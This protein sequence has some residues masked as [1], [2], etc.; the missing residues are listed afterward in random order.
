[1]SHRIEVEYCPRCHWLLRAAWYAQELLSTFEN[2]LE[3]V[4]LK[5]AGSGVFRITLNG[6]V[7]ADR[8]RDHGFPDIPL[9]K[10]AV[11]DRVAP[12]RSLGHV[13]RKHEDVKK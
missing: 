2:E 5:P 1:M 10:Q 11:R 3:A 8:A 4:T 12:E 9:L 7:L 13:D 6:E